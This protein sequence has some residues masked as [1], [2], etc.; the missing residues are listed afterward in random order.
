MSDLPKLNF[1]PSLFLTTIR[2]NF[3]AENSNVQLPVSERLLENVLLVCAEP[4]PTSKRGRAN[5][6]F[7]VFK[8]FLFRP[9]KIQ[10]V[11]VQHLINLESYIGYDH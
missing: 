1:D 11:V 10:E 3:K 6:E 9:Q 8:R 7:P 4:D 5:G 2:L